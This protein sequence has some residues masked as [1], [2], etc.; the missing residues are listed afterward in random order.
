MSGLTVLEELLRIIKDWIDVN[1]EAKA[2]DI[3]VL[4]NLYVFLN[5]FSYLLVR[6]KASLVIF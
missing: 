5:F 4:L 3:F 2:N 1:T 6:Q